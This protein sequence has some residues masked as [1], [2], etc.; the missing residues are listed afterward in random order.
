MNAAT[1]LGMFPSW[2]GSERKA[3][4]PPPFRRPDGCGNIQSH[5]R[6]EADTENRDAR[7]PSNLTWVMPA[8]GTR[9]GERH[10]PCRFRTGF[11]ARIFYE[12]DGEREGHGRRGGA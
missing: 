12:R 2:L 7:D 11:P 8:K 4:G 1:A 3:V 10:W 6:G 5:S 9:C